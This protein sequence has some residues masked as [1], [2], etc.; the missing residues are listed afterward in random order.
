MRENNT[1]VHY[2]RTTTF[3]QVQ[4]KYSIF[5]LVK[6]EFC[7]EVFLRI[8]IQIQKH[9]IEKNVLINYSFFMNIFFSK[10]K[11]FTFFA[12]FLLI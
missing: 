1:S 8:R 2:C 9:F 5:I 11:G 12:P 4:F 7:G 6:V 10:S 3:R